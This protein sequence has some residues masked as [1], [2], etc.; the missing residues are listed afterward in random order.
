MSLCRWG[1]GLR[2]VKSVLPWRE[3][4]KLTYVLLSVL[5]ATFKKGKEKQIKFILLLHFI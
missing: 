5:K 2:E 3:K 4:V 1:N